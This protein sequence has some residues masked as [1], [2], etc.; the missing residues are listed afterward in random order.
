[1]AE[2]TLFVSHNGVVAAISLDAKKR[3]DVEILS[4]KCQQCL[5]WSIKQND[6]KYQEWKAAHQCKI[7]H[8]G[9]SGSM[10]TTGALRIFEWSVAPRGLKYKH[11]LGDGDSSTYNTIL[12]SKPYGE[13]CI[14]NKLEC[15]G[16][17]QNA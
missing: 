7:N 10:E 17:V 2:A 13:D 8:Y 12:E 3:L 16:H 15:I 4:D 14:P 9:C 11:M 6:P 5:K 1:M